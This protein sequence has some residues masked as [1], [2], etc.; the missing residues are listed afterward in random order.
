MLHPL[1]NFKEFREYERGPRCGTNLDNQDIVKRQ[2]QQCQLGD[3]AVQDILSQQNSDHLSESHLNKD[4]LWSQFELTKNLPSNFLEMKPLIQK[5]SGMSYAMLLLQSGYSPYNSETWVTRHLS[6]FKVSELKIILKQFKIKN[7]TYETL[8]QLSEEEIGE[9]IKALPVVYTS[10]GLF[11]KNEDLYGFSP[12]SYWVYQRSDFQS[13]LSKSLYD[14]VTNDHGSCLAALGRYCWIYNSNHKLNF[15]YRYSQVL[16]CLVLLLFLG[17]IFIFWMR[18]SERKKELEIK[19][20]SL[21]LLSHEF[22]TPVATQ[23]LVLDQM[24][25]IVNSSE[26]SQKRLIEDLTIIESE[27]YRL[28]RIIEVT[29]VYLQAEN[30][31]IPFQKK[32]IPS[33]NHWI[34]DL[35]YEFNEKHQE[36][37]K[38]N[39]S[40]LRT[41]QSLYTDL[42]WLRYII[43]NFLENAYQHGATP[44]TLG[45]SDEGGILSI[46]VQDHGLCEFK[47]LE[48][49]TGAFSKS[50]KSKGMGLGLNIT[51]NLIKEWGYA[52]E[53]NQAP[54]TFKLKLLESKS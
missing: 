37:P 51:M 13:Y 19:K 12:L 17:I 35:A 53:F 54:T 18:R 9:L 39:G 52:L 22:R 32:L 23:L 43:N 26:L 48:E 31:Q 46:F 7:Q 20:L 30:K 34:T 45:V 50:S 6:Y 16:F 47:S 11:I 8:S 33:I 28:Q 4:K 2:D 3:N 27:S 10:A 42:F 1:L 15:L 41:D 40:L 5:Q 29:R 49:M 25:K 24:K 21:Q 44:I 14:L 38:I 36:S